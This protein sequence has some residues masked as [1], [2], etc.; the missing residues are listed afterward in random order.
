[1]IRDYSFFAVK[2]FKTRK[3]RTFLTMLG[4][5]I[6]IAAVVSLV[7]LGQ[8][9]QNVITEQFESMGANKM[10]ISPSG[11]MMGMGGRGSLDDSDLN[12]IQHSRGIRAAGG[13]MTKFVTVGFGSENQYTFVLGL[14]Q[15]ESKKIIEDLSSFK[16]AKGRDL[17]Q[18]DKLKVVVGSRFGKGDFFDKKVVTG[19]K[20]SVN[21]QKFEVIGIMAPIGN[22]SDDSQVYISLDAAIELFGGKTEFAIIMAEAVDG[23]SPVAAAESVKRALRRHRGLA[24]GEEDFEVQTFEQMIESFGSIFTIVQAVLIG[25]AGISLLVGGIGI[26]NTMY[27]SVFQRTNEI[28]IMKAVGARNSD[29]IKIFLIESGFLG[30]AGGAIGIVIGFGISKIVEFSASQAGLGMLKASF[31]WYLILGSLMFSFVVGCIAG[32]FPAIRASRLKPVDALRY[33]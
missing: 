22:P 5:F 32:C 25:I 23:I 18:G 21:N 27:T 6:G 8:G 30:M 12:V 28:G 7:S 10:M 16:I 19:D 24:E 33:E 20:I 31:P 4:I 11:G 15:D 29:I 26:M 13:F 3:L 17:K 1:M 2:Q 14:P 9:L